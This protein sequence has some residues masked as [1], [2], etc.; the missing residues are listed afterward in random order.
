MTSERWED[1]LDPGERLLWTGKPAQGVRVTKA[2]IF[3][4]IG[5]LFLLGFAL[6][7][8]AGASGGLWLPGGPRLEGP[9]LWFF[10]I[11]P[12]FGLPFIWLGFYVTIG[13]FFHDAR[14]RA[15]TR[16]ALTDRRA[17]IAVAGPPRVLKS[18][19]IVADTVID[20][21]PGPEGTIHL[22]TETSR[23]SDGDVTK[24]RV[25]FDLIPEADHVYRLIRGIQTGTA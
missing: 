20:Y 12:L 22:A 11:F 5:G 7:W 10:I 1:Y 3:T 25:G 13:H 24:T 16:Y 14:Q 18:W 6:F 23:D 15:K 8:T 17:L 2:R 21:Q 4:S 19:P 9:L